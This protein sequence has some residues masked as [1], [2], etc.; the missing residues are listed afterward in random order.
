M[1]A[2]VLNAVDI[3]DPDDDDPADDEVTAG[4]VVP[5]RAQ[6]RDVI[7]F[8][9]PDA[10]VD[11]VERFQGGERDL[12]ILSMTA[13]DRGYISQISE[14]LLEPNRFNVGASRMK[15]K[16]VIIASTAIFEESSDDIDTF[17]EQKAWINF[18]QAMGNQNDEF[19][20]HNLE[21]LISQETA[22]EFLDQNN[23]HESVR[24]Y[25]GYQE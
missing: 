16:V 15:Q 24:M 10:A 13:S 25:S 21:D 5:F 4:V 7:N 9:S 19:D 23:L 12:M 2:E 3:C 8:V 14:F 20:T 11:T 6:R 1:I 17:E 18:Y 22:E